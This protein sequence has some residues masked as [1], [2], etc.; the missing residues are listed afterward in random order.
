MS[1]FRACIVVPLYDHGDTLSGVVAELAVHELPII[2]VDDGSGESTKRAA[3]AVAA[4]SALIDLVTLPDNTG[5]GS[6]VMAGL[7]R[8]AERGFTHAIQVD[9]DGQHE[10]ADL[11]RLVE[12]S[13]SE[14]R[15]LVSGIPIYDDSIPKS[16][17]Y[18]RYFTHV[19]VWIETL[20]LQITDTMCG[21]R[22][23]P[24]APCIAL[25]D[26]V[27]LGRRMDFDTEIVVRLNWRGVPFIGVPTTVVYPEGGISHFDAWR[28]NLY[29]SWM[30]TRLF[31]GM[32][33]RSP[34]LIARRFGI[35]SEHWSSASE[36]GSVIYMRVLLASHRVMGAA[37][38]RVLL[39]PVVAYFYLMATEAR[40]ASKEYLRR[41]NA[42]A[43]AR[44]LEL[45]S[46]LSTFRHL[47]AFA[48]STL[49]KIAAWAGDMP[50]ANI[51]WA[52]PEVG[53]AARATGRGGIV[54]GSHL[55][56]LEV[57]RALGHSIDGFKVT[58]LVFTR[59]AVRFNRVLSAARPEVTQDMIQVDDLGPETIVQ[60]QDRVR[61]GEFIGIVGDRTAVGNEARSRMA[62]FLGSPAAFAEGPW[63]LAALLECPV[64]LMFSLRKGDGYEMHLEPFADPLVLPRADRAAALE[65][66][67]T[68]YAARL[69]HYCLSEP[70]QWFNFFDFWRP[71]LAGR[72]T[73]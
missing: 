12:V 64:Y 19:W 2:I 17:L 30:H 73:E 58:A 59:N 68:R 22:V 6:A 70:L 28:D 60:L 44:D 36:R 62:P 52:D 39:L 3:A 11:P 57:C 21:F 55:G 42:T 66:N 53:K 24:V 8:A 29:I 47:T 35:R 40:T 27:S 54:I 41:I 25:M 38:F 63:I 37:V 26:S 48:G 5:K 7:R 31:F 23:Y 18:G 1:S 56:N 71:P 34:L 49:D 45:P 10:L 69:E 4:N 72:R 46:G 14:P 13:R 33:L 43:A 9:A 15:A 16:R 50:L 51:R 61:A 32:L 20:S 65:R 67:I